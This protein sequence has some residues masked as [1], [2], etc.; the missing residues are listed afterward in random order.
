L[1]KDWSWIYEKSAA[2]HDF[3]RCSDSGVRWRR[4]VYDQLDQRGGVDARH[5]ID[6]IDDIEHDDHDQA[7]GSPQARAQGVNDDHALV[8]ATGDHEL[9]TAGH[10]YVRAQDDH[11][12]GAG[13][14]GRSAQDDDG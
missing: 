7:E 3:G 1:S 12:L 11:H 9:G 6:D 10:D 5:D 8:A 4:L 13:A 2:Q 14:R